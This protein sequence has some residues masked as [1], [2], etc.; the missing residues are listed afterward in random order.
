M[1][2]NGSRLLIAL[3]VC[4]NQLFL[5]G[6]GAGEV[7]DRIVAEVNDEI[8]TMSELQ[9]MAKGIEARG[10]VSPGS[11][12]DHQMQRQMLESLIDRKLAKV[13]AK[14][15]GITLTEKEMAQAMEKFMRRNNLPNEE[16]LSKALSQAG[17]TMKE[18]KQQI[19][20][21]IIQER[22][23]LAMVGQKVVVRDAD[24]RRVYDEM[25][26]E[27]GTQVHLRI[28]KLPIPPG[29]TEAQKSELQQKAEAI[30]KEAQ[31]GASFSDLAKKFSVEQ[32]DMGFISL[33]DINPR[34]AERLAQLKSKEVAP[35]QVPEGF[36]LIQVVE[37]RSGQAR[38]FEE[39]APEIKE[40]LTQRE[41][42]KHFDEWIKTLRAKAHIK[43]ML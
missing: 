5:T 43:I 36:Q 21:Q 33:A 31:H 19:A 1:N 40:M 14:K 18:L 9:N 8:I 37:R 10:G 38:S 41:L 11:K 25:H 42:E 16:T 20:D 7:V 24:I 12:E 4:L 34:L 29:G 13:E 35:V 30:V 15:R 22:L 6:A 2:R 28:I 27:G 39:A 23:L 32:A 26:K 3:F 17:L